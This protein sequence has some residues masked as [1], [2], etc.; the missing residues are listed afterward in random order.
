MHAGE[1]RL[2][3][4]EMRENNRKILIENIKEYGVNSWR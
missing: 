4:C 1:L 3:L 2:P